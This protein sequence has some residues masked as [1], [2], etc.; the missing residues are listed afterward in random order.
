MESHAKTGRLCGFIGWSQNHIASAKPIPNS[1]D[2]QCAVCG[3]TVCQ[4]CGLCGVALHHANTI[5]EP[6]DH[7]ACFH[8]C[9]DTGCVGVPHEDWRCSFRKKKAW[10]MPQ[11]NGLWKERCVAVKR[12]CENHIIEQSRANRG[13]A[14][15]ATTAHPMQAHKKIATIQM[16][17]VELAVRV[18]DNIHSAFHVFFSGQKWLA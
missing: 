17:V 5:D 2:Q 13:S 14:A 4:E 11:S 3:K 15:A 16:V 9:H 12:E 6:L 8:I 1:G 7:S 10:R 18:N